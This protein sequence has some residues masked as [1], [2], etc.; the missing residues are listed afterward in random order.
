M[1]MPN[2]G[3]PSNQQPINTGFLFTSKNPFTAAIQAHLDL[4]RISDLLFSSE[5]IS[6]LILL[7]IHTFVILIS[8]ILWPYG[9]LYSASIV[10]AKR[11]GHTINSV[12]TSQ[13]ASEWIA[14]AFSL[15]IIYG[16]IYLIFFILAS[17]L[18]GLWYCGYKISN[19]PHLIGVAFGFILL[20]ALGLAVLA[21]AIGLLIA[22]V[23]N[24]LLPLLAIVAVIGIVAAIANS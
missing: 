2:L 3:H 13:T 14:H 11:I 6:G 7:L 24:V 18:Y 15:V 16:P 17:P 8:V 4:N 5:F 20:G 19:N 21:L 23:M 12:K 22:F 9:M 1:N 10:L